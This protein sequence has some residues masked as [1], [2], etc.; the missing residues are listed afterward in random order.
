MS[1]TVQKISLDINN[2]LNTNSCVLG[3]AKL[4]VKCMSYQAV[5]NYLARAVEVRFGD[6]VL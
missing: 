1:A 6:I 2:L 4:K 5:M 3:F